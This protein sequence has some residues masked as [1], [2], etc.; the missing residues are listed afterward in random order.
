MR[1]ECM[2]RTILITLLAAALFGVF[3]LVAPN[4]TASGSR[5][6]AGPDAITTVAVSTT[7]P[8][9]TMP[10]TSAPESTT[11]IP[12]TTTTTVPPQGWNPAAMTPENGYDGSVSL[13]STVLGP[14]G[15]SEP[16]II[17]DGDAVDW[18]VVVTNSTSGELWG[19]YAWVEGFGRAYCDSRHLD[20]GESTECLATG[21]AYAGVTEVVAWVNA[22]TEDRQVKHKVLVELAVA[23]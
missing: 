23:S 18:R 12:L 20:A 1:N 21:T 7:L 15:S 6:A 19:V 2:G 13:A 16:A 5:T 4:L 11:T 17:A 14:D 3:L 8:A 22:W 10:T 9:G